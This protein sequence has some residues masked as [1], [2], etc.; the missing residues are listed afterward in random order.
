MDDIQFDF[1]VLDKALELAYQ[2]RFN[3]N[4]PIPL[5]GFQHDF[6]KEKTVKEIKEQ[7]DRILVRRNYLEWTHHPYFLPS[8]SFRIS[9]PGIELFEKYGSFSKFIERLNEEISKKANADKKTKRWDSIKNPIKK[10]RMYVL[11]FAGFL[12]TTSIAIYPTEARFITDSI[13][14]FLTNLF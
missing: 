2:H 11:T 4:H 7:I 14:K 3:D 1:P 8:E 13:I 9:S 5:K 6:F 12:I 10:Y